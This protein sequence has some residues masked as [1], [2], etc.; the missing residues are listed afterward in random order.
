MLEQLYAQEKEE[1]D[2]D[3]QDIQQIIAMNRINK[4]IH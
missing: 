2:Y 3:E 1:D 4:I